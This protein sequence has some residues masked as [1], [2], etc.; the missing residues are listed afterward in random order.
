MDWKHWSKNWMTTQVLL[1]V[2]LGSGRPRTV[3]HSTCGQFFDQHFQSTKTPVFVRKHFKQSLYSIFLILSQRFD[4]VLIF[5]A[6]Y[7]HWRIGIKWRHNYIVN[8]K[9]YVTNIWLFLNIYN[10]HSFSYKCWNFCVSWLIW[11]E[12]IKENK[13]D[14]FSEHSVCIPCIIMDASYLHLCVLAVCAIHNSRHCVAC[15][16]VF[17]DSCSILLEYLE[18]LC[19]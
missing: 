9:E 7:H 13:G 11:L 16:V 19:F 6:N 1:F 14:V 8:S 10:Q 3:Q 12:V 4:Q 2:A 18:L 5:S 15:Y 17:L